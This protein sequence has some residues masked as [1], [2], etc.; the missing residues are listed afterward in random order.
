MKIIVKLTMKE[1]MGRIP[2]P[3]KGFYFKPSKGKGSYKR[4]NKHKGGANDNQY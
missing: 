4:H 2:T 3:P 1:K